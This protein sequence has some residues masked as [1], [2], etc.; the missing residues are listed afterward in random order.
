MTLARP[1]LNVLDLDH[2]HQLRAAV[3]RARDAAVVVLD[4]GEA[5][6]FSAGNDVKDHA[7]DR[8]PAMLEAFHGAVEALLSLDAVT[9][10]DVRGD[11]LGGGCELAAA[12]DLVY[13]APDARFGQPEIDVGCFPPVAASLLPRRIGWDR[14][15]LMITTGLRVDARTA[16]AWGLVTEVGPQGPAE[17]LA[18]LAAKS[19]P[20]LR[21]TM[22]GL[23]AAR[24]G[25][26]IAGLRAAER[27]YVD[28]LLAL[29]DCAEGVRAFLA[30]RPPRWQD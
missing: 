13:A 5:R 10:A 20:V 6:A 27:V 9:I 26:A 18:A 8:A 1:A 3:E 24:T 21:A 4:G 2:L 23:R 11:A 15:V 25:P 7:P 29:P 30:K 16:Q 19:G 22:R 12:C 28:D 14:A 17:L